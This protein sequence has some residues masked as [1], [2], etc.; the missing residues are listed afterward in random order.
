MKKTWIK[1]LVV[2]TMVVLVL[3]PLT[4]CIEQESQTAKTSKSS[5]TTS[6]ETSSQEQS[7]ASTAEPESITLP[8]V[9]EPITLTVWTKFKGDITSTPLKSFGETKVMQELEKRT[10]IHIEWLHVSA[11]DSS[12]KFNLMVASRDLPDMI[13]WKW[14]K[15]VVG[16]PQT[17][18][19][20]NTIIRLNENIAKYGPN[21]KKLMD[22]DPNIRKEAATDNGDIFAYLQIAVGTKPGEPLRRGKGP[23]FRQDWLDKLNLKVPT[24]IDEWYNVLKA[25]REQDPNGNGEK[26]EVPFVTYGQGE[27]YKRMATAWGILDG[28]YVD[29]VSGQVKYGPIEPAYKNYLSTMTKWYAEGLIDPEFP[30]SETKFYEARIAGNLAGAWFGGSSEQFAY[31]TNMADSI[32]QGFKLIGATMPIGPAGK[33]YFF[34]KD[35]RLFDAGT[36]IS[37]KNKHIKESIKWLDYQYSDEGAEMMNFG[38]EGE[39]YIKENGKYM[40]TDKVLKNPDMP[41]SAALAMY[42]P[43]ATTSAELGIRFLEIDKPLVQGQIEAELAWGLADDSIAMPKVTLS[44]EEADTVSTIMNEINTYKEEMYVRFVMGLEP[45][46]NFDKFVQLIKDMKINEVLKIQNDALQRYNNR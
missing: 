13:G 18:L 23:M 17:L 15:N 19:N 22:L 11:A 41:F 12:E 39:S 35:T 44:T 9:T 30:A 10:G 33:S 2:L 26:D 46:D 5:Q 28:F 37:S 7:A 6:E 29:P 42:T 14:Y 20:N 27:G 21:Y 43:I 31:F 4:G 1:L 25:F 16:G 36:A 24:T 45:I 40:F 3:S 38:I 32:A 8:I 34:E